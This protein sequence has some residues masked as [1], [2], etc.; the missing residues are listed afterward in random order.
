MVTVVVEC[1]EEKNPLFFGPS[2]PTFIAWSHKENVYVYFKKSNKASALK[3]S[4]L[5]EYERAP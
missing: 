1:V 2:Y 5:Y 3:I 4:K